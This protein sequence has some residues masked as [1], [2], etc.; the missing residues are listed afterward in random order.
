MSTRTVHLFHIAYSQKTHDEAPPGYLIL[1]H[2]DNERSDWREYWP[3]RRFLLANDLTE[4]DLYGFFSPRFAEKTG[5]SHAQV[6]QTALS[7]GCEL[8]IV[9]FSPQPDMGAFFLNLF[10]QEELFHPGFT[11]AAQAFYE[12]LGFTVDIGSM[13]MDSRQIVFSN[14]FLAT[15]AF[16][17]AWLALNERLFAV[18]EG[19]ESS[20]KDLLIAQTNYPG[21]VQRKVFLMERMASWLLATDPSWQVGAYN[22]FEC[23]WSAS[24]L[25]QFKLEA[26]MSD[27]L[28]IAMREQG[29]G[30]YREAFA[31][32]RDRLR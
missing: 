30:Q 4:G 15:P 7:M 16:W 3:I 10:E 22:T 20:L 17:R 21:A 28:K 5:L 19:E 14:Y 23:A 29:F 24:R 12:S 11:A 6:V 18:C 31:A 2:R 9:T 32:L 1:D 25:N 27:A 8:D 13:V 26:V